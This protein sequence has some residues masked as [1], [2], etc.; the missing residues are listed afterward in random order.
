MGV[1]VKNLSD[2][3]N[4]SADNQ[5]LPFIIIDKKEAKVFVFHANGQLFAVLPALVGATI[6]DDITPGVGKKKISD[7][8]VEERMTPAGRFVA[9][10]GLNAN[11]SEILWIDYESGLSMHPVITNNPAEHR[12]QRLSS[13]DTTERRITYGCINISKNLYNDFIHP[14][15]KNSMGIVYILPEVRSIFEVF[16]SEAY[17]F[18]QRDK[19]N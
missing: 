5:N 13:N 18:T 11:K 1:T 10:I 12:L 6:G 16:G 15:F 9:Q 14:T 19:T 4:T 17:R 8:S 3:I 2:W 7:I